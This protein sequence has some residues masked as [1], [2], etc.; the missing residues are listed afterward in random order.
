M[1]ETDHQVEG[2]T[3]TTEVTPTPLDSILDTSAAEGA[4]L[5]PPDNTGKEQAPPPQ[6]CQGCCPAEWASPPLCW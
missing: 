3:G 4:G 5:M 2:T 1:A 6:W